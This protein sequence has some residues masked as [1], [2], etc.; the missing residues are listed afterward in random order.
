[1]FA[2]ARGKSKSK[3]K[4]KGKD[5]KGKGGG[6]RKKKKAAENEGAA[7]Y[8]KEHNELKA[9]M[10]SGVSKIKSLLGQRY[11]PGKGKEAGRLD[12]MTS[13]VEAGAMEDHVE[14]GVWMCIHIM[15][16][17]LAIDEA[18]KPTA[19]LGRDAPNAEP[20]L[21]PPVGRMK[22]SL[23]PITMLTQML[24][25]GEMTIIVACCT[26]IACSAVFILLMQFVS[27]FMQIYTTLHI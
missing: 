7:D 8:A 14:R 16:M 21:P 19:G 6:S 5:K 18:G 12:L 25:P 1:M 9:K 27:P 13:D 11:I 23:N 22:L 20:F 4:G 2:G 26:C 17:E 3:R 10:E 24:G 15:P